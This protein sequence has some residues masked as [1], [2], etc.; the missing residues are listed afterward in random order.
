MTLVHIGG[1]Y[2]HVKT[3]KKY[4]VLVVAKDSKTLE[5]L[6]VYEALYDHQ[7]SKTWVRPLASFTGE[8]KA[9]DGTSHPRFRLVEGE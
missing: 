8:A 2:E 1:V 3:G 4:K 6:V 9:A 7:L 5:D